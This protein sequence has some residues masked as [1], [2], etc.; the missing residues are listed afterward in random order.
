MDKAVQQQ[1][2]ECLETNNLPSN[3]QPII[4]CQTTSSVIGKRNTHEE[5]V[6][7]YELSKC[8]STKKSGI[9]IIN[10]SLKLKFVPFIIINKK[11]EAVTDTKLQ[12][13]TSGMT[14]RIQHNKY[15]NKNFQNFDD[16]NRLIRKTE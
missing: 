11:H 10:S 2:L 8:I 12:I 5:F 9:L 7:I 3:C 16:I 6:I 13:I 14:R 15:I 4:C 1:L